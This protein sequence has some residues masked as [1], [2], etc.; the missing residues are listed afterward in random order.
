MAPHAVE[1]GPQLAILGGEGE[2]DEAI[3]RWAERD[4]RDHGNVPGEQEI[5]GEARGILSGPP[6]VHQGRAAAHA[7]ATVCSG[8]GGS[9]SPNSRWM[10]SLRSAASAL[11]SR[12][13]ERG[14]ALAR[15]AGPSILGVLRGTPAAV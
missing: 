6:D 10:T 12:I 15:V 4:A 1:P 14:I 2:P 8:V 11:I 3:A 7:S 13:A 9:G 5:L